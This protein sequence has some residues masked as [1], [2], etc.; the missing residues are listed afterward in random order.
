M[1]VKASRHQ[2]LPRRVQRESI[3]ITLTRVL[4]LNIAH[5]NCLS[6]H[7][8]AKTHIVRAHLASN[9]EAANIVAIVIFVF[10]VVKTA[11]ALQFCT[12]TTPSMV[13]L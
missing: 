9:V 5:V 6:E 13:T 2:V 4:V 8:Q 11:A 10:I 3:C 12:A 7:T 1:L